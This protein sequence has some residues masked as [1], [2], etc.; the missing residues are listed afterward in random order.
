MRQYRSQI[1]RFG[2]IQ[3]RISEQHRAG[4]T[5]LWVTLVIYGH[6]ISV[7]LVK[8]EMGNGKKSFQYTKDGREEA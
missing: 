3:K 8:M 2:R 1:G 5:W 7:S 6:S 4:R